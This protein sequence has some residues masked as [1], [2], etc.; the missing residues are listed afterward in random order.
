MGAVLLQVDRCANIHGGLRGLRVGRTSGVGVGV[1]VGVMGVEVLIQ[2]LWP[3]GLLAAT[4]HPDQAGLR[5]WLVKVLA[6][7]G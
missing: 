2:T 5:G 3:S 7:G 6:V 4:L 1:G